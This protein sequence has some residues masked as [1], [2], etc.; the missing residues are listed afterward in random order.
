M[1]TEYNT[2]PAICYGEILWDVLPDG[3]Q[4]GGAPL[5]VAYHLN[6][7]GVKAGIISRIGNDVQGG[8]LKRLLDGWKIKQDMLQID[9]QHPTSEVIAKMNNENEVSY[10]IVFPVA[11]DF[12]RYSKRIAEQIIPSTY[13]VYG[14]L[15]SRNDI[16]RDTLHEFL[17]SDAV[18]V[19]DINLRP[20]FVNRDILEMLLSKADIVKFNQAELETAQLLFGGPLGNELAQ[21]KFIQKHFNIREI[22]VTKGEF[23]ASY[24]KEDRTFNA[25]GSEVKVKDTIGSGDAFLAAFIANHYLKNDPQTIIKN[26]VAMGAFVATKKGGCPSYQI[27]EYENFKSKMF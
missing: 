26:S 7:L 13:F 23:G 11:W 19:F 4:P 15:A 6:K 1:K 3:P 22:I 24:Y 21:I 14:S 27:E 8:R 25:W 20:P 2:V 17:G 10:E 18:K 5:N 9:M 16:S 12:I